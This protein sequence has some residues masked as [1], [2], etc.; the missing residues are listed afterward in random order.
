LP[1]FLQQYGKSDK[2]Y[3]WKAVVNL[4]NALDASRACRSA[5]I[6]ESFSS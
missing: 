4:I 2:Y 6:A 3:T 1:Q 5:P